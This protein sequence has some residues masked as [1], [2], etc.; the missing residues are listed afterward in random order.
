MFKLQFK[1]DNDAFQ[2]NPAMEVCAILREIT[3]LIDEGETS[4]SCRD[5]NGNAVGTWALDHKE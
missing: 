2:P 3:K 5:S 4:G 1:T